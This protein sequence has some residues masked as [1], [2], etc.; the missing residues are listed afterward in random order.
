MK[1]ILIDRLEALILESNLHLNPLD[2][3]LS[4]ILCL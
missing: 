4:T 3:A 1:F 2:E